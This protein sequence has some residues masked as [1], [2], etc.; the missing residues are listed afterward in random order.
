MWAR[1]TIQR[2]YTDRLFDRT[3]KNP[4][5]DRTLRTV[6]THDHFGPSTHQQAALDAALVIEP[7]GSLWFDNQGTDLNPFGGDFPNGQPMPGRTVTGY[8]NR[9]TNDGGPTTWQAG[10][11]TNTSD[12]FTQ[13]G[14]PATWKPVIPTNPKKDSFREFLLEFQ[15]T[16]LTYL[17]FAIMAPANGF[18]SDTGKSCTPATASQPA[19]GCSKGAVCYA[20]FCSDKAALW[21]PAT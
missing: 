13:D 2:W 5:V 11:Q 21:Q 7:E 4:G 9:T 1:A 15:D 12:R 14:G 18:C 17:P 10:I 8:K 6:F 20:G 19:T 16:T 3:Y